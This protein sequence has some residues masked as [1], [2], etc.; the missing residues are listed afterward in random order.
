M[1]ANPASGA[2]WAVYATFPEG[3]GPFPAVV[4]VPGGQQAAFENTLTE[5]GERKF[6]RAGIAVVRYD[7]EGRGLS[8]GQD[9]HSGPIQQAGLRAM[10]DWAV[11]HEKIADDQVGVVTYSAG[12]M[13]AAPALVSGPHRAKFLFDWEG[14]PSKDFLAGCK[15][16]GDGLAFRHTCNDP[17]FW[18]ERDALL[19]LPKL[20]VPYWRVQANVDHHGGTSRGH[21]SSAID[22]AA[23]GIAPWVRLNDLPPT[24]TG[25][26]AATLERGLVTPF[27]G[28]ERDTYITDRV[29]T[30][31]T[32]SN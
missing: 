20:T 19:A 14:P 3:P 23:S 32:A 13:L 27:R 5:G 7:A 16:G 9:D 2:K 8:E 18:A 24:S 12:L 10:I 1:V 21:V 28:G 17:A 22:A 6:T 30:L 15:S 4:F 25:Y 29:K 26:D 31:F 11:A